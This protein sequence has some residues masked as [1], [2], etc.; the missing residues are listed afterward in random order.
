MLRVL[1]G[2]VGSGKTIV[3]MISAFAVVKAGYQVAF[4]CPTELLA[5]QHCQ[6]F[7]RILADTNYKIELLSSKIKNSEQSNIRTLLSE[8]KIDIVI[9]THS[10]FQEKTLFK[11]LGLIIIDEQH[12][13]GVQ[14]RIDLSLK[15]NV[16]TD[17][18]LMTATPIPRTLILTTYGDMDISTIDE[19]PF[20]NTNISTL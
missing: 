19:K 20:N 11:N 2:D 13:F 5:K 14:Q 17:V 15:G 10:L 12:K 9:G 6:L 16:N 18:L 3:S 7:K 4:L 8:N 1:Q